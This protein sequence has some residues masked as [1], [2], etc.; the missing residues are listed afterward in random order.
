MLPYYSVAKLYDFHRSIDEVKAESA[1]PMHWLSAEGRNRIW[2]GLGANL[3]DGGRFKL[4]PGLLPLLLSLFAWFSV[5]RREPA[6][7]TASSRRS[8]WIPWLDGLIVI[9]LIVAVPVAGTVPKGKLNTLSTLIASEHVLAVLAA[10][11]VAR[12]CL[13]YPLSLRFQNANLIETLRS[14]RRSDAFWLGAILTVIG[15][16]YSLGWNFFFY[17]ILYDLIPLFRSMRVAVRGAMIAYLGIAILTGLGATHLAEVIRNRNPRWRPVAVLSIIAALLLF[18]LNVA[19]LRFVHGDADPDA[20]SLRLKETPM[21]AGLV[22]LPANASVNHHHILRA[23]DHMKPIII[24]TSGFDSPYEVQIELATRAGPFPLNFMRYLEDIPTSY[25]VIA[26]HLVPPERRVDYETFLGR[27]VGAGR[28]RYVNRFDG[29]DD[30]YAV[31]KNEPEAK[32][33]APLPFA[34]TTKDWA[35]LL[36][37]DPVNLL[38]HY[39]SCAQMIYR[40]H[41]AVDGTMPR[42]AEFLPEVIAIGRG[43]VASS[44]EDQQ[45]RLDANLVELA[46]EWVRRPAFRARYDAMNDEEFLDRL[47]A[48]AGLSLSSVDRAGLLRAAGPDR[49]S[50]LIAIANRADFAHGEEK[51]SL[52]L[53]HYFGYLRRNPDDPPDGDLRG[54]NFWLKEIER[55][56]EIERLPRAFMHSIEYAARKNK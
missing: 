40:M 23:A 42:Y 3:P 54:F 10:A 56:G 9:A 44:L 35:S 41:L 6:H 22:V 52:V 1:R 47:V 37:D 8:R 43:V 25:L 19:R 34:I 30:L 46:H 24:G 13:A 39:R 7:Q 36:A 51:R 17:R 38:G 14:D 45:S 18:E 2:R 16:F 28:L 21:K 53:L 4:F 11:I 55:S 50:I 48:N 20:V 31:V 49:G 32:T 29:R 33:E 15:F 5:G 26:N 12:I 27:A